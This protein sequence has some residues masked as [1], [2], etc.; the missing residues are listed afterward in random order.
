MLSTAQI[1]AGAKEEIRKHKGDLLATLKALINEYFNPSKHTIGQSLD[2][3]IHG[4]HKTTAEEILKKLNKGYISTD[5]IHLNL[6]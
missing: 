5:H 1:E 6:D 3:R 2:I 4:N